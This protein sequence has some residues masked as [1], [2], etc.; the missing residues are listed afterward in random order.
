MGQSDRCT[1]CF[2][3]MQKIGQGIIERTGSG[4]TPPASAL[5]VRDERTPEVRHD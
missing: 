1:E 2:T 3:R 5:P 4:D